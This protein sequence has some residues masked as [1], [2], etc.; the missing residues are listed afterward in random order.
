MLS[1]IEKLKSADQGLFNSFENLKEVIA[2]NF[3]PRMP[4]SSKTDSLNSLPHISN[5]ETYFNKILEPYA[6]LF[7][8]KSPVHLSPQELYVMLAS[9]WLHDIGRIQEND[10]N[11]T[12]EDEIKKHGSISKEIVNREYSRLGIES[13][14]LAKAIGNICEFHEPTK[15]NG[16][17]LSSVL[18]DNGVVRVA[19]LASLLVLIDNMDSTYCR[20]TPLFVTGKQV[21]VDIVASFRE[22]LRGV[23]YDRR[24]K[25]IIISLDN[26][27]SF[28]G[29][30]PNMNNWEIEYK[31]NKDFVDELNNPKVADFKE[32]IVCSINQ[33]TTNKAI[34]IPLA[35]T[36]LTKGLINFLE[37]IRLFSDFRI[38][39]K[40]TR[41]FRSLYDKLLDH[42]EGD[43]D[44]AKKM[45]TVLSNDILRA[46]KSDETKWPPM[47]LISTI[48]SSIK[49]GAG[50]LKTR[51][52]LMQR[53]GLP[54][55]SWLLLYRDRLYNC[56]GNETFEP[57]FTK[58]YLI[59]LAECMWKL[60]TQVFGQS[61]FSYQ[62]LASAMIEP[63]VDIKIIKCLFGAITMDGSG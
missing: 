50:D 16:T 38:D 15:S 23:R 1:I 25:S 10:S 6:D 59:D 17:D 21:Y 53:L 41:K 51:C 40:E 56:Y 22:I 7:N 31:M 52:R 24:G 29:E 47:I 8:P 11:R 62:T 18:T 28:A 37:C 13:P 54:V 27:F 20:L 61:F 63:D 36:K 44:I 46:E 12:P 34:E 33:L 14:E 2:K 19:E 58:H 5:L 32:L 4:A 26:E 3:F 45:I 30:S 43:K 9:I 57:I 35:K 49:K 39:E 55:N 48:F 60:S 42:I